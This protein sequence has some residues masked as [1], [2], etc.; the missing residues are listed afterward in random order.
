[1]NKPN[2]EIL[3]ACCHDCGKP[4]LVVASGYETFYRVTSDCKPWPP[5]G[6]LARC[7]ACG[8]VQNPV[9]KQWGEEASQ[10]YANYTIYHQSGGAEQNVFDPQSGVGK[11]RSDKL[12]QALMREC[13]LP[14]TG[15]LLD[16]GCGNGGF[17]SAWS[18]SIPG[19]SLCGSEVS[20]KY[21]ARVESIPGVEQLFTCDIDQI[22]GSFDL[23]SL[24]HVLEHIPSPSDFLR[25][26]RSKLKPGGL[27]FV[28]VPDCE[29]SVFMLLVAD[30]C[31]HF[32]PPLLAGL[33]SAAGFEVLHAT[34][35]WVAKEVSVAARLF[36]GPGSTSPLRLPESDSLKVFGGWERL[37]AIVAK[38]EPLKQ[39]ANFGLFGTAIA[40]TWLDAQT[41]S[42]A[43]FFVEEDRNRVGRTHLGRPIF[44]PED[45]PAQ[46]TVFVALPQPLA[47]Q[48]AERLARLQLG[49]N[50]VLP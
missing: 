35:T 33:V 48:V 4:A 32:S 29:Q 26:V 2:P 49:L 16:I 17:L 45:V 3:S 22:P 14:A 24:V 19:W 8:L 36:A 6:C 41:Q 50:V 12:I 34:N 47:G 13:A 11:P 31:S 5:G 21:K 38:I 9:T 1:M 37:A 15:R 42:A 25:R 46:A 23:I 39:Q 18:R 20:D 27:L 44:A 28:E 10:I 30:H 40:A 43:R 7:S